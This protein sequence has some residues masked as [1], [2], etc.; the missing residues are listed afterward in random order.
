MLVPDAL[1]VEYNARFHHLFSLMTDVDQ[2]LPHFAVCMK[3]DVIQKLIM[4]VSLSLLPS[5]S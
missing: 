3:E 5:R 1:R 4:M 2:R